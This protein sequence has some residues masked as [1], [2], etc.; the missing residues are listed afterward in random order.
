LVHLCGYSFGSTVAFEMAAKRG[1]RIASLTFLDGS[2]QFVNAHINTYKN[3]YQL[4][5]VHETEAEAL[6]TFA[7]Q[8]INGSC[9]RKQLIDEMLQMPTFE[10]KIRFIVRELTTKSQFTFEPIDLEQAARAYVTKVTMSNKYQPKQMLRL[11]EALLIKA[12]QRTNLV[13]NLG[14]DYGLGQVIAGKVQVETVLGDHRSF[15]ESESAFQVASLMN[16]FLL[17]CF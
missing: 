3:K 14:E 5:S 9:S 10:Q 7:Q 15:L 13:Q 16:E 2:H 11:K 8:F 4:E 17:R 12:G 6:C 1:D